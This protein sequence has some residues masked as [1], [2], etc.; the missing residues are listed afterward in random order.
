G[1]KSA[2]EQAIVLAKEAGAKRA[3]LLPM[4]VPSHCQLM[5]PAADL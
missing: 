1:N 2:V 4:S 5:K 3:L